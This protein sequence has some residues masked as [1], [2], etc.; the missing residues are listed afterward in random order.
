MLAHPR[1]R[2]TAQSCQVRVRLSETDIWC[3]RVASFNI[4]GWHCWRFQGVTRSYMFLLQLWDF[5]LH[6]TWILG[7]VLLILKFILIFGRLSKLAWMDILVRHCLWVHYERIQVG[8]LSLTGRLWVISG[9]VLRSVFGF[10]ARMLLFAL[11]YHRGV[12]FITLF[13]YFSIILLLCWLLL[14]F[15]CSLSISSLPT[16]SMMCFSIAF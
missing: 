5:Q 14:G 4:I 6:I 13:S 11:I 7:W 2:N 12:I 16:L 3:M 1:H 8:S 15:F 10:S 9:S